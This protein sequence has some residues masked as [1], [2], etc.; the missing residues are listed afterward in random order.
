MGA[1]CCPPC[2]DASADEIRFE[3]A[4]IASAATERL[5]AVEDRLAL[6]ESR[7]RVADLNA[8]L[9]R[10]EHRESI[11]ALSACVD[12]IGG[13]LDTCMHA[14]DGIIA[15]RDRQDKAVAQFGADTRRVIDAIDGMRK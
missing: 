6:A 10:D 12:G 5:A 4:R 2:R 8:H 7:I 11:R 3:L 13:G 1:A 9:T 14:I 15:A